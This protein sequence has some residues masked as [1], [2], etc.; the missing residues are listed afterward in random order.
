MA[1][2]L[3]EFDTAHCGP[4]ADAQL[5][6]Y[7]QCLATASADGCVRLWD[8]REPADPRFLADLGGHAG[9]VH[10]VCWAPVE[11]GVLLASACSDGCVVIWGRGAH[12]GEWQVVRREDLS[13]HGAVQALSWAAAEHGAV[14][15]CACADGYVAVLAHDGVFCSGAEAEHLWI[16]CGGEAFQAHPCGDAAAVSWASPPTVDRGPSSPGLGGLKGARFATAGGDGV[17]VWRWDDAASCW[18]AE[19]ADVPADL[20]APTRDVAWRAWDGIREMLASV[21]GQTVVVWTGRDAGK[22]GLEQW[23]VETRVA[24]ESEVW[25]VEWADTGNVLLVSCGL[26]GQE[27]V[28]VKQ[29]LRRGRWDVMKVGVKGA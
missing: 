14:L 25:K 21:H 22:A 7:G 15:A 27:L 3:A 13:K 20:A 4:V 24:I 17:K 5:D 8:V 9:A 11:V 2:L 26:D 10:Q 19:S 18:A 1:T 16:F 28:V 12:P 29:Q 6:S 23:R